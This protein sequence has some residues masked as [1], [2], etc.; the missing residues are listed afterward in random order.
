M[1]PYKK[2]LSILATFLVVGAAG[3]YFSGHYVGYHTGHVDGMNE[4]IKEIVATCEDP[5]TRTEMMGKDY[6]CFS[7]DQFVLTVK[8][9]INQA[10]GLQHRGGQS[11]D[12]TI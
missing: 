6:L 1:S 10:L 4:A 3:G 5:N 9:L 8:R 12:G 7:Q 2:G 11:N